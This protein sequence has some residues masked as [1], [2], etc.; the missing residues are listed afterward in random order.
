MTAATRDSGAGGYF[1][2]T[3]SFSLSA[4]C[5]LFWSCFLSSADTSCED[6]RQIKN[7]RLQTAT[8]HRC[9]RAKVD[10]TSRTKLKCSSG[11]STEE[12]GSLQQQQQ[13][14]WFVHIKEITFLEELQRCW[15]GGGGGVQ[16]P[17][18][19]DCPTASWQTRQVKWDENEEY[20][21]KRSKSKGYC[22]TRE[23][24]VKDNLMKNKLIKLN[25][26]VII[27]IYRGRGGGGGGGF[28]GGSHLWS[29]GCAPLLLFLQSVQLVS[30]Q[31][32]ICRPLL[33]LFLLRRW[34]LLEWSRGETGE[35]QEAGDKRSLKLVGF[36]SF[37]TPFA[38]NSG[39][40]DES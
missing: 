5:F 30:L 6:T 40:E 32:Q 3:S 2:I 1:L 39:C 9:R 7:C 34:Q 12:A 21:Q 4:R 19:W 35:A 15:G 36:C 28:R 29:C 27:C 16:A 23:L 10:Q 14:N 8:D 18:L 37:I 26:G 24:R 38:G 17:F 13:R 25:E 20:T 22:K 11:E 33:D 31:A